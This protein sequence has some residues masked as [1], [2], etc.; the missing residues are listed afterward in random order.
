MIAQRYR[1]RRHLFWRVD[2]WYHNR[3]HYDI[4]MRSSIIRPFCTL[5]PLGCAPRLAEGKTAGRVLRK[6]KAG[7]KAR[8]LRENLP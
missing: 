2:W 5:T 6:M 7:V 3:G 1:Q 4:Q 8:F